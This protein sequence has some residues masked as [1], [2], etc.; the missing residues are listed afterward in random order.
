[1]R[2]QPTSRDAVRITARLLGVLLL[3]FLIAQ[4]CASYHGYL[5]GEAADEKLADPDTLA[6]GDY[7]LEPY[8]GM[9]TLIVLQSDT[10]FSG[11][12]LETDLDAEGRVL[13]VTLGD[14][15][16]EVATQEIATIV[17]YRDGILLRSSGLAVGMLADAFIITLAI[18]FRG[19]ATAYRGL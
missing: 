18:M 14:R 3:A 17:V 15:E 13:H 8:I 7:D 11:R 16:L 4:G 10:T 19:L 6:P 9:Q 5:L 1:M 2:D 12:L